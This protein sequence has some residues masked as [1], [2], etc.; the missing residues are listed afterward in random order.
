[1]TDVVFF[2]DSLPLF[3]KLVQDAW[4]AGALKDNLFLRDAVGR[5]TFVVIDNKHPRDERNRLA[6]RARAIL[7]RYVDKDDSS[8]STPEELFD[9]A[10]KS[11]EA[12]RQWYIHNSIFDGRINLIDRR[13]VGG[14]WLRTPYPSSPVPARVA[15]A[16][17]KGGVGRSTALCVIAAHL[18]ARGRRILAIDMDLEAPGLGNMLLPDDTLPDFGLLDW[19]AE[20]SVGAVVE[21]FY[22]DLVASS[23]LGGGR[24]RV[25]VIPALGRKSLRSPANVLAKLARAYLGGEGDSDGI[26][27]FVEEIRVLVDRF[28]DTSHYDVVLIDSRA[29]LHETTAAAIIGLGAHVLFFGSDQPQTYTGYE[30]LLAQLSTF[31]Q[32]GTDDWRDRIHFVHSKA[33]DDSRMRRSFAQKIETLQRN[34]LWPSPKPDDT[35]TNVAELADTFEVEWVDSDGDISIIDDESGPWPVIAMLDDDRFRSFDPI[36]DRDTLSEATYSRAFGEILGLI[37]GLVDEALETPGALNGSD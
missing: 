35:D 21:E 12:L 10:L 6:E 11:T 1:M 7:G 36:A 20:R 37:T 27:S 4:G 23:W 5:L 33:P 25:D 15:F 30:I 13:V 19:L 29:G 26:P 14:D 8:V 32:S 24:G 3:A 28:A 16:S 17:V 22:A 9:E 2:D 31:L 34:Y 18:A